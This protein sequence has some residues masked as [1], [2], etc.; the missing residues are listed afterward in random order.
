MSEPTQKHSKIA[1]YLIA[2]LLIFVMVSVLSFDV[3]DWPNPD[4]A[5]ARANH[6]LCG[7]AGAFIA[8]YCNYYL[9]PATLP[10]LI[11]AIVYIVLT[12]VRRPLDQLV[13]RTIG[14]FLVA[15]VVAASSYLLHHGIGLT[16]NAENTL[17][18]GYGGVLGIA[19]GHF[20]LDKMAGFGTFLVLAATFLVGMI[21]AAD[22][23]IFLV[24]RFIFS[25]FSKFHTSLATAGTGALKLK[26]PSWPRLAKPQPEESDEEQEDQD[27]DEEYE[28]EYEYEDEEEEE[29]QDDEEEDEELESDQ[30]EQ[31]EACD[32]A[33][34][35]ARQEKA[36][37]K[38]AQ[39][40]MSLANVSQALAKMRGH[41]AAPPPASA[42]ANEYF[43]GFEYPPLELLEDPEVGFSKA[44]TKHVK[45]Q[46]EILQKT[47][48]EFNIDA[49]V[50]DADTGPVITFFEIQLAPGV[51][52]SQIANLAN[53][54]SRA[55]GAP[56]VRVVAPIPGKSTIGIEAPNSKKEKVRIK[57]LFALANKKVA[58]MNIPLFLG[59]DASGAPL[60]IDLTAMPHCLIAG[61]TGSGKSVCLNSIILSILLTQRPDMVKLILVDP[62]MV[63]MNA[64][65]DAP[66]LMCPIVTEMRKAEQILDWLT[67][68]MDE[69][70]ALL[71]EAHVRNIEGYNKLGEEEIYKRFCPSNDA[72]RAKI[73]L[74]L[75]YV[76]II[77]DELAD[78]MMTSAKEVEAY[79]IRLAQKSRAV[80]IHIV[81]AT[82][83]PQ[84]TVVT[85]LIKSN[86][87]ARISFRVS[88]RMDSRIVLD[89]NGA[90]TLLGQGDML[91]LQPGT[92]ELIRAQGTF[93]SDEETYSVME[94]LTNVAK[95]KYNP[96]LMQLNTADV[97]DMEKDELFD[98]AVQ[99]VLETKRG[100]VSLL[101]RRLTIGY[102]RAS[103]LIDQM[104]IAGIVGEYKGSQAREVLITQDDYEAIRRQMFQDAQ[105][106]YSDLQ[107]DQAPQ[108][109]VPANGDTPA[110]ELLQTEAAYNEV[111][112][113]R[114]DFCIADDEDDDE[115]LVPG[116]VS[117][118]A[119]DT[120]PDIE[121]ESNTATI[122][123]AEQ[124]NKT[125][126]IED[127]TINDDSDIAP[128]TTLRKPTP[129]TH[130]NIPFDEGEEVD[131]DLDEE[132]EIADQNEYDDQDQESDQD[133][134]QDKHGEINNMY[135][136]EQE[137][138]EGNDEGEDEGEDEE[139]YED[140]IDE[141]D[142][143]D[144]YED[145]DEEEEYEYEEDDDD[146]EEYE[147]DD[148]DLDF[149]EDDD[150]YIDQDQE[151]STEDT[152]ED[153]D[154]EEPVDN[155]E[156]ANKAAP[157]NQPVH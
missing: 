12:A 124:E 94:H 112:P 114:R 68:K 136:D 130:M 89:Q 146:D 50:V 48:R 28:Y 23:L 31:D 157:N 150:E 72:E 66:H 11:G 64:F 24:P 123:T 57:E 118:F 41:L 84:A 15:A 36:E 39:R 35:K 93:L 19:L 80:G 76:V 106:G 153:Q 49:T 60:I 117:E 67:Q 82:Q 59:K 128:T 46:G 116:V 120:D 148:D 102:S 47:L 129:T 137:Y 139:E 103:R 9:G 32:E 55:L 54:M 70:Y 40:E 27:E 85:G 29:D 34:E 21:L 22:N 73:P 111:A 145:D 105:N 92:S 69:R 140:E 16:P 61:T 91:F 13:L 119:L 95:P 8:Y 83:R 17:S 144:E 37:E 154:E 108:A 98:E 77:I 147:D 3:R 71:A 25:I 132:I 20:L 26:L 86:L 143:E 33:D 101:Q 52:V 56:A 74:R 1:T 88:A 58:K 99:I 62:K 6:N 53:D 152:S 81:L 141:E 10:L 115:P 113:T 51:K 90:E 97:T 2:V 149:D 65:R 151:L 134:P 63:E 107:E 96:E 131:E 38:E 45:A 156:S 79:I 104:A 100:S 30:D 127:N 110:P 4:V 125:G 122:N 138:E 135:E 87:P 75:P 42:S 18:H 14:L 142:D 121:R 44:Q 155:D 7:S 126:P 5:P 78:L 43:P 133:N 109:A